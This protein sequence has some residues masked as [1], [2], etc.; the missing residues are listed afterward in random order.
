[1]EHAINALWRESENTAAILH[2]ITRNCMPDQKSPEVKE[3]ITGVKNYLAA[4]PA[5]FAVLAAS[6]EEARRNAAVGSDERKKLQDLIDA[7]E[8]KADMLESLI[9]ETAELSR[10]ADA[11]DD[12]FSSPGPF[13]DDPAGGEVSTTV[14]PTDPV[15]DPVPDSVSTPEPPVD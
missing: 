4:L 11:A 2:H 10:A 13:P 3:R 8:A 15:T 1:M 9:G 7:A 12:L 6:L 14:P 5:F